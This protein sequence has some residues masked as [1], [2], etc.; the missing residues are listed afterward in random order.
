MT[1][2]ADSQIQ[3]LSTLPN[4]VITKLVSQK[5]NILFDSFIRPVE[6]DS[7]SYL[8]EKGI[9]NFKPMI[10]PFE[11]K[12]VRTIM[13]QPSSKELIDFNNY[14]QNQYKP[15]Y[16]DN[17]QLPLGATVDG[18]GFRVPKK[19]ISYGVSSYGYDIRVANEFKIFTNINSTV[20]DPKNFDEK[21][22][23]DF[24]GDVCIIPPNSFVLARSVEYFC[25]PKNVTGIVLG[26]STY[27]RCGISTLAT[28]LEAGW[29]G[30]ITLEFANTTPLP[31]M[32][33]ANEGACQVLF[34]EG[35]V[36]CL[37]SY[38]DRA[39]KYMKQTGIQLPIA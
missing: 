22:F 28:P 30:Y 7:F 6:E 3:R 13:V 24:I 2:L 15:D 16:I 36:D 10:S 5:Q 18:H 26:K 14:Q 12:Q 1:I 32:I 25:M 4:F 20:V 8:T 27:A 29:E 37:T 33:Y 11:S 34:M 23:V 31:A 21:S 9:I 19:V 39:G 17:Y 35:E 38:A